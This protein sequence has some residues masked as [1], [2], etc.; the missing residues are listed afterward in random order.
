MRIA[1]SSCT[2]FNCISVIVLFLANNIMVKSQHH[3]TLFLG[4]LVSL[5]N[6]TY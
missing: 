1:I 2:I 5:N 3:I 4:I 6:I